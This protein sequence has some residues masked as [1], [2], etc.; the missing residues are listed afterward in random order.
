MSF[1][2]WSQFIGLKFS[3]LLAMLLCTGFKL[4]SFLEFVHCKK[5]LFICRVFMNSKWDY[6]ACVR[7]SP[8]KSS[9]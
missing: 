2:L 1:P 4:S 8:K 9:K 7:F 3:L 6:E 5:W